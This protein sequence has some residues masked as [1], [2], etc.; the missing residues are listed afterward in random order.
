MIYLPIYLSKKISINSIRLGPDLFY[1]F[2][3]RL[4]CRLSDPSSYGN[5]SSCSIAQIGHN[6]L[7]NYEI[8][9][10]KAQLINL[11]ENLSDSIQL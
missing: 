6:Y 8:I 2:N 5:L 7:K 1:D 10:L 3:W 9:L 4:L 11:E